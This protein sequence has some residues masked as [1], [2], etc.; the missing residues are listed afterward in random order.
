MD[1]EQPQA[2][3]SLFA[4]LSTGMSS[5]LEIPPLAV[6]KPKGFLGA[7]AG[8]LSPGFSR[9]GPWV[10]AVGHGLVQPCS[11]TMALYP[12]WLCLTRKWDVLQ[13]HVS[14]SWPGSL[15]DCSCC[16]FALQQVIL[17]E[18]GPES[19]HIHHGECLV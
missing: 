19:F 16:A 11:C 13:G 2:L 7:G 14:S 10:L 6:S 15:G 17:L 9:K 5:R 8:M 4:H 3:T 18:A 1:L 12:G